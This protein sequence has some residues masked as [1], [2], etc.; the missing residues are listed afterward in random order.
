MYISGIEI[1]NF[2]SFDNINIDFHEGVNVLIGHNN[3]GKSNL[4]RALAII[5][6]RTVKKQ[7]SVE[8]FNN[9]L[10][11]DSLKKQSPK[12]V[13]TVRIKQSENEDLM[14][15]ELI[16]V[17]NWLT[18]LEE[19]YEAKIQYEFFLPIS[20]EKNYVDTVNKANNKEEIWNIIRSQFIRLYISKIWGGNP[21]NQVP[22]DNDN[23]NKF[24]FQFLDAIR[25][26]ERDMFSGRNTLL[27]SV[28]DFFL[29]YD[30]KSD[31]NITEEEQ[32]I[33]LQERK[34]IFSTHS[35]QLIKNIQERLDSGNQEILSYIEEIG[36]S[37]DK[38]TPD[39]E[40]QLSESEI[41]TVLQLIVRQTTGMSIPITH[42]GLGY[43]N[44]IFMALLL[45]KMQADSDGEFLGSNAKVF[46]ILAIEEPEAHLHPTMQNEF[47]KFLKNNI[48]DKKVKQIFITT[49]STHISSSTNIDDI[50]C[51]YKKNDIG[52]VSY[53]GRI[54]GENNIKS[55]KYVQRFLDATKSNMLFAE[56]IIFVEGL[57]EQLLLNI[58]A[59][60]LGKSLEK[61][62]VAV[63]NV[64]GRY[65][66]HFLH[67]FDSNNKGA[68]DR[69]VSCITDLDPV[70]KCKTKNNYKACYPFEYNMNLEEFD[71]ST[72]D[73]L[74][75]YEDE[76]HNNI[77]AFVQSKKYGKTFEYQL[78]LDNPSL[79]LLL[80]E[81]I[82][83]KK[84]LTE[85]MNLYSSNA[86][87]SELINTLSNSHEN[88]RIKES[89]KNTNSDWNE[90][91]KK[92]ALIAS[93]YLNSVGK[94]E[95]ALE[96]ASVLKDNLELKNQDEYQEF[97]VPE[98]I[99]NAIEWVC[100]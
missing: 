73:L 48:K 15:D 62:H 8:D 46:P 93:R 81:S 3:S 18:K 58:F 28:I 51:L 94:G 43:N 67:L 27:K 64:G 42:N 76:K 100:E 72:N 85:L 50:I 79:K 69:K 13:I 57:A 75:K 65:F 66:E 38:S 14:T 24:D 96:L 87:F 17:S 80:T 4:L 6:D 7:L 19:P 61:N 36:A 52:N 77:R 68:I 86:T 74:N 10:T 92:K 63:I 90:E 60:Y 29:D 34:D 40:G 78:I 71:Y 82:A 45:S 22:I 30:I 99:A 39:F 20:E 59:E 55:K 95:N 41:Y 12:I 37:Y 31:K 49:H 2:R 21:E 91:Q 54:L 25:D 97:I 16:T 9:S 89:L 23:L 98:Y 47:I 35:S 33:K 83:N 26:V 88:N 70:R 5:F 84:E 53:P 32:K 11:I 56:K 44:L 1:K